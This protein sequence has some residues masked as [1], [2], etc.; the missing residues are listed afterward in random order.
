MV[1]KG[2]SLLMLAAFNG[3]L[4]KCVMASNKRR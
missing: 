4:S 2:D 1:W 3:V